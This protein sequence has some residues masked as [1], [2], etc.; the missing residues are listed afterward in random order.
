[1]SDVGPWAALLAT[2]AMVLLRQPLLVVLMAVAVTLN[3]ERGTA[4]LLDVAQDMWVALDRELMLAIPMY[5]LC[6][7]LAA[8]G[9]TAALLTRVAQALTPSLPGGIAVATILACA[10]YASISGSSV[11]TMLAVGG[12]MLPAMTAA[13]CERRYSLGAVTAGG[14]LGVV[15]PPSI[16]MIVFAVVTDT[17]LLD[18]FSAGLRAGALLAAVFSLHAIW[19][20]RHRPRS[21]FDAQALRRALWD[22]RWALMMPPLL[23]AG[24]FGGVLAITESGA[25]IVAYLAIVECVLHR[26]LTLRELVETLSETARI[27]GTLF[28]IVAVA[29]V[30]VGLTN[31]Q[32]WPGDLA[33]WVAATV[34]SPVGFMVACNLLLLAAGCILPMDAAILLL[35]PLLAPMAVGYGWDPV[36][37]GI[38]MVLNLEI[39]FLTPPLGMNLIIASAAYREPFGSLCRAALPFIGMMMAFLALIVWQ[40]WLVVG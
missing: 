31:E 32:S 13:G 35:A 38:V 2:V 26:A 25:V 4:G 34:E 6:G 11:V 1:M 10:L 29:F 30:L 24:L 14:T 5:V 9:Q 15:I 23:F 27:V 21:A 22:A 8:R 19:V 20:H 33:A 28:P 18:L 16:P 36:L 12:V 39:G 7:Q 40:P 37:F 3:R 17:S